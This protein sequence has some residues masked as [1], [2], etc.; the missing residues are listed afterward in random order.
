[1]LNATTFLLLTGATGAA[2]VRLTALF[3]EVIG[4]LAA[5]CLEVVFT[6]VRLEAGS[7]EDA[8]AETEVL[9]DALDPNNEPKKLP[10]PPLDAFLYNLS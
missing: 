6:V 5:C 3:G 4:D 7:V 10:L 1:M 2:R 9:L 8:A